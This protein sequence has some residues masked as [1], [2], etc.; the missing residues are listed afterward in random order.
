MLIEKNMV[1][2]GLSRRNLIWFAAERVDAGITFRGGILCVYSQSVF[3]LNFR[4]FHI[5]GPAGA[6][7]QKVAVSKWKCTDNRN[8]FCKNP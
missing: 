6:I 1:P 4:D 3:I 8:F 2:H 5:D 7:E